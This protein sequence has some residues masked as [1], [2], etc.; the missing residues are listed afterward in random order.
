MDSLVARLAKGIDEA[1]PTASGLTGRVAPT[2]PKGMRST[3]NGGPG[4]QYASQA[5]VQAAAEAAKSAAGGTP[6]GSG[7]T[8][9]EKLDLV[10]RILKAVTGVAGIGLTAAGAAR[11]NVGLA[12]IGQGIRGAGGVAGGAFSEPFKMRQAQEQQ[13][14]EN[15]LKRGNLDVQ[16]GQLGLAERNADLAARNA[17]RDAGLAKQKLSME[18]EKARAQ[19]GEMEFQRQLSDPNSDLAKQMRDSA[20]QTIS[21]QRGINIDQARTM[22]SGLSPESITKAVLQTQKE[23]G[24]T[25]RTD[26]L[27]R[28]AAAG[29]FSGATSADV[30]L[31][32]AARRRAEIRRAAAAEGLDLT[33]NDVEEQVRQ[34]WAAIPRK[35]RAGELREAVN[36]GANETKDLA[37]EEA[38]IADLERALRLTSGLEGGLGGVLE[39][40]KRMFGAETQASTDE[41]LSILSSINLQQAKKG[42]GTVTEGDLAEASKVTGVPSSPVEQMAL[43]RNPERVR[44]LIRRNLD[45]MRRGRETGRQVRGES[46]G[47]AKQYR[48]TQEQIDSAPEGATVKKLRDLGDGKFL[49]EVE[50]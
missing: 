28:G 29:A 7:R 18:M 34:Q 35:D 40:G 10:G 43:L 25:G 12:R 44:Q 17:E 39:G 26:T 30:P 2:Q 42:G 1:P 46:T 36:A 15:S 11:G 32:W 9:E 3:L 23:V 19:M 4:S 21:L 41:V 45:R 37:S 13:D 8:R 47:G 20:A 5:G 50:R 14:L 33:E 16:R 31:Q 48:M 38:A 49:V 24:S 22:I 6:E 27:A